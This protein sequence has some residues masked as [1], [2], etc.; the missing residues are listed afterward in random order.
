METTFDIIVINTGAASP[1]I[2]RSS[3][4]DGMEKASALYPFLFS[5]LI[6]MEAATT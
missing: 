5:V 4:P 2:I 6:I 1:N 3:F